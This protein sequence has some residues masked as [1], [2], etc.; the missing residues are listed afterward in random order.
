M[1]IR[2]VV[3][4]YK[5]PEG[6]RMRYRL[7]RAWLA[8][9]A[10][11]RYGWP[12]VQRRRLEKALDDCSQSARRCAELTG[13]LKEAHRAFEFVVANCGRL[14]ADWNYASNSFEVYARFRV[15]EEVLLQERDRS[16]AA[17]AESVGQQV[18]FALARALRVECEKRGI[19]KPA[20]TPQELY[21][22]WR[23]E[24]GA[25]APGLVGSSR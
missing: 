23:R 11:W 6:L 24:Q 13:M 22:R 9:R 25:W 17:L 19:W 1:W 5:T 12:W 16:P 7:M 10:R 21:E 8:A 4:A 3:S 20:A 18:G 2:D 15:T 14:G